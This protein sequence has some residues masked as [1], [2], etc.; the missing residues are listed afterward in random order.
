MNNEN[1]FM[2]VLLVC[3]PDPEPDIGTPTDTY[4]DWWDGVS[5][6]FGKFGFNEKD[7]IQKTQD[8]FDWLGERG[9]AWKKE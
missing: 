4:S 1:L 7:S 2:A 6:T 3:G 5:V 8:Y 9:M